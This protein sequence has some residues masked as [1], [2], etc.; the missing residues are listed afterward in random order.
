ML[1][2]ALCIYVHSYKAIYFRDIGFVF[3][4]YY[5]YAINF[6]DDQLIIY[7]F[8]TLLCGMHGQSMCA[9]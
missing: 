9:R 5:H 3:N 6:G 7:H 8:G 1:L 2:L 4:Y